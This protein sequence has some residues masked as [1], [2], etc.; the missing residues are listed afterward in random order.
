M[1][2]T[3]KSLKIPRNKAF[4]EQ[5]GHCFYC[6][7]PMWCEN[8]DEFSIAHGVRK[9][10]L[11]QCQCTGEHLK[12]HSCGGTASKENIVAACFYCNSKRHKRKAKMDPIQ[13]R[14]YVHKRVAKGKWNTFIYENLE[15]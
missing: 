11:R 14:S 10:L 5:E 9:P 3:R 7:R 4:R 13:Y 8:P 15:Q 6:S 12:P 1:R 2:N